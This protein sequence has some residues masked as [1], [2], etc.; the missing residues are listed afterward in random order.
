[1]DDRDFPGVAMAS[2]NLDH[3]YTYYTM[4]PSMRLATRPSTPISS[5]INGEYDTIKKSRFYEAWDSYKPGIS[6]TALTLGK[7][8]THWW[9]I[10]DYEQSCHQRRGYHYV[11]PCSVVLFP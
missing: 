4:A 10:I 3:L 8:C 5:R 2:K 9:Y 6:I 1:M 7:F 11:P